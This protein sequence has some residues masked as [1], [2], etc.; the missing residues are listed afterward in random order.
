MTC[1]IAIASFY[2]TLDF[3]IT[4]ASWLTPDE[5]FL[6]QRRMEEDTY[7]CEQKHA[8]LSGLGDA[9]TDWKVWWLAAAGCFLLVGSSFGLFFPTIVATMGYSPTVTLLL[10]VPPWFIGVTASFFIM[11]SVMSCDVFIHLTSVTDIPTLPGT[12][13]G[14]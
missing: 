8:P 4:P 2:T 9:L 10:C 1:I 14:I 13:S 6:A 11:R 3:P 7:N 5:Q 12:V